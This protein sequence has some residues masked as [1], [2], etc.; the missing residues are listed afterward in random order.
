MKALKTLSV[1]SLII[2]ATMSQANAGT[3]G[4]CTVTQ[5]TKVYMYPGSNIIGSFK[6]GKPVSQDYEIY[7]D[8]KG[9]KYRYVGTDNLEGYVLAKHLKCE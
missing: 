9:A 4:W 7:Y 6:K 1:C 8:A 2:G 3:G 5:N